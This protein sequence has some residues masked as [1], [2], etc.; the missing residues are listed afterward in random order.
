MNPSLQDSRAHI[1]SLLDEGYACRSNNL[2]LSVELAHKALAI[3]R[4]IGDKALIAK[5][6]SQYALFSMIQGE[7]D[8]AISMSKEAL[9]YFEELKDELGVASAKY[10]LGGVY[11]KTD[12]YYLGMAYLTDCVN[13]YRKNN[14]HQNLARA[15]KSLGT[16]YDYFGD[17]KN[18]IRTYEEAI[19]ES[20]LAGDLNQEANAYNP[21]ASIYLK[22]KNIQKAT[23]LIDQ[24]IAIK[25]KTGD[26]RG[27]AFA[28][29][30]RGKIAIAKRKYKAAEADIKEA[31]RI[32]RE[33]REALGLGMAL[34]R[35]AILYVKMQ[36]FEK[37]KQILDD[38]LK[39][40]T[41]YH[42][43]MV[44]F[45]CYYLYYQIY[46]QIGDTENAL[47]YLELYF[48]ERDTVINNQ[49]LKLIENYEM[50]A[51]MDRLKKEAQMQ[52][53]RT[54][55]IE[56]KNH[57]EQM[58]LVKQEFL[59]TM[60]HEI[61]TPLNAIITIASLLSDRIDKEEQELLNSLRFASNNLLLLIN[62]ILDFTK[63]EAGKTSLEP[64]P[65]NFFQLLEN[66]RKTYVSLASEK[67]VLLQLNIGDGVSPAYELDETKFS[68][69]LGNLITNAI[70]FTHT[71]SVQI[72]VEKVDTLT[73]ADLLRLKV[74]DTGIGISA[75]NQQSIFDAF[76]QPHSIT[77][78]THGGS[79]LGLAIVKKLVTLYGSTVKVESTVG[80]G[81][82]FYFDLELKPS[83]PPGKRSTRYSDDL[84]GKTVL[85]A[86]DNLINAMVITRL[87][88][89]W[90]INTEHAKNGLEALVK[91]KN[92]RFDFILMDIHMP[93]MDG[94]EAA[95]EIS[96]GKNANNN[97]PI[98]ALTADITAE[99]RK[100]HH[101]YFAGFLRKPI[102]P[103]K[104]FA[105]LA[106][107]E[108]LIENKQK[109]SIN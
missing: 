82:T 81:S 74:I 109:N 33:V 77:K 2:N 57:A 54:E 44:K 84:S 60:S 13:I 85:L 93:E 51:Q 15:L 67:G 39:L 100:E 91:S 30:G 55:I 56:K 35:L 70:K 83:A 90:R 46:K 31:I 4:E 78:K 62:D 20:K 40:S 8:S 72:G 3:S 47:R 38:T 87:L 29:Y 36:Q 106:T 69:I 99:H 26:V 53:E 105:A 1:I 98:F 50:I 71:G 79:G 37:A 73:N 97:T 107:V 48:K 61:R 9:A 58:A 108:N 65:C 16:I 11:Y 52:L 25:L 41:E 42:W 6:L 86:E 49:T 66:I 21:L 45:K 64:A 88:G 94:F 59:S 75:K 96:T 22:Q 103:E 34:H 18:A 102:E 95:R 89:N 17:P 24:S 14:D 19:A 27:L 5:S 32:H 63:L 68:Q 43:I 10:N 23:E 12:N 104:L 101:N 28:L 92:N 80:K 7:Y 76:T